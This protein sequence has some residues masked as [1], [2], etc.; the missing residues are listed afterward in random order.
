MGWSDWRNREKIF[1]YG[2]SRSFSKR[3]PEIPPQRA[4]WKLVVEENHWGDIDLQ[5]RE[6]K[7]RIMGQL[8]IVIIL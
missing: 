8:W 6:K 1:T 7:E 5:I 2:C 4:A 3:E